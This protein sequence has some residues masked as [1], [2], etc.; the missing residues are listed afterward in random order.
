MM[1]R[2]RPRYNGEN[3]STHVAEK[4]GYLPVEN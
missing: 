3:F 4:T 2:R 1:S